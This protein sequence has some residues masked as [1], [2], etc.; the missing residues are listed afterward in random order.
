MNSETPWY[1]NDEF[2]ELFAPTIFTEKRQSDARIEIDNVVSLLDIEPGE[3]ILDLCCGV[4]R[5][6]LELAHRGF[7]VVGVDRTA[8][9]IE[10]ARQNA[11][12]SDLNVEFVM[13]GMEE[14]CEPNRFDVVI[15]M[16]G[17][18]GY[19]ESPE[20]DRMVAK[21]MHASLRPGGRF[22]IE[23]KGREI[24]ARDFQKRSWDEHGD[25]LVLAERKPVENWGRIETRYIV[26]KGKQR[27]EYIVSLRSFSSTELSSLLANCGFSSANV[28]GN[29]E[30]RDYDHEAERLVVVGTK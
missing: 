2:W 5:H 25:M 3:Q 11:K 1:N 10:K 16:F 30:G 26:I 19:L 14:F 23:T 22:L 20:D 18:F 8:T 7:N 6:S 13:A 21:N 28:Y 24:A 29:L 12:R 9:Y 15:N 4:G 27:F 17:S